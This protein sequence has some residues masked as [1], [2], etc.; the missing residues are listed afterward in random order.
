MSVNNVKPVFI[1][2][3]P[4]SGSTLLQRMLSCHPDISTQSELWFM[5]PHVFA[6][7]GERTVSEYSC[8]SLKRATNAML[9][10]LPNGN[11]DYRQAIRLLADNIYSALSNDKKY[12]LDKTPRYYF[13]INEIEKIFPDAKFIFLF[14]HPCSVFSSLIESFYR[15]HLGDYSHRVDLYEGARLLADGYRSFEHENIALTYE[16]LVAEPEKKV[17]EIC[18]YLE[19]AYDEKMVRDFV[20][21]SVGEMGDQ[22]GS[23][24][25]K[26]IETKS[27]EKWKSVLATSYRKKHALKYIN[28]LGRESVEIFGY[29]YDEILHDIGSMPVKFSLSMS[30]RLRELRSRVYS[31]LE[32]PLIKKKLYSNYKTRNKFYIHH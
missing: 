26:G 2:S 19:I 23:K 12:V 22:F 24:D 27:V 20:A 4:R 29:N 16:E 10:M 28:Y 31:L 5:L 18:D 25:Y 1:F 17:R 7:T 3:L 8:G 11:D 30:D 15:G 21:M 14:R 13:I 6:M 9:E 32:I